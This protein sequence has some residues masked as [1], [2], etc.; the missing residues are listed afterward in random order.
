MKIPLKKFD[1]SALLPKYAALDNI[2]WTKLTPEQTKLLADANND[3]SVKAF[4]S[5]WTQGAR[6]ATPANLFASLTK[7]K[8]VLLKHAPDLALRYASLSVTEQGKVVQALD[9]L[10]KTREF[11]DLILGINGVDAAPALYQIDTW[12]KHLIA[13]LLKAMADNQ[14][15]YQMPNTA[16]YKELWT[17]DDFVEAVVEH[18]ETQELANLLQKSAKSI[19]V[20]M[21]QIMLR[22]HSKSNAI[23]SQW[24][25]FVRVLPEFAKNTGITK[26]IFGQI[27]AGLNA[28]SEEEQE[29]AQELYDQFGYGTAEQDEDE[30]D[31]Q[32]NQEVPDVDS[33][34]GSYFNYYAQHKSDIYKVL[35]TKGYIKRKD[36]YFGFIQKTS[37]S[38]R[39]EKDDDNNWSRVSLTSSLAK[40]QDTSVV[41]L[42]SMPVVGSITVKA[43]FA[44][45]KEKSPYVTE[46]S[47]QKKVTR[48]AL[49]LPLP[50]TK[51]EE[52]DFGRVGGNLQRLHLLVQTK[53]TDFL[54]VWQDSIKA[55]MSEQDLFDVLWVLGSLIHKGNKTRNLQDVIDYFAEI[56]AAAFR[57][58]MMSF[59]SDDESSK[60]VTPI[61]PPPRQ[62]QE[63]QTRSKPQNQDIEE[64]TETQDEDGNTQTYV[65]YDNSAAEQW[66]VDYVT[67]NIEV[68][69]DFMVEVK[70]E[71]DAF[72]SAIKAAIDD[73]PSAIQMVQDG[74]N[75]TDNEAARQWY[76][77]QF[78]SILSVDND[79][80]PYAY[81]LMPT[82]SEAVGRIHDAVV[83]LY[84]STGMLSCIGR[85]SF[86]KSLM[87]NEDGLF[88]PSLTM[89]NTLFPPLEDAPSY[90]TDLFGEVVQLSKDWTV[91]YIDNSGKEVELP[92][93]VV[94][95][96]SAQAIYTWFYSQDL[97]HEEIMAHILQIVSGASFPEYQNA[98]AVAEQ[99]YPSQTA[100]EDDL[101]SGFNQNEAE[102]DTSAFES[103]LSALQ[104]PTLSITVKRLKQWVIN[105]TLCLT[106]DIRSDAILIATIVKSK[107]TRLPQLIQVLNDLIDN[108]NQFSTEQIANFLELFSY[109]SDQVNEPVSEPQAQEAEKPVETQCE[110]PLQQSAEVMEPVLT[111]GDQKLSQP[112][113]TVTLTVTTPKTQPHGVTEQSDTQ[114]VGQ[115]SAQQP[116]QQ[117][118]DES[119]NLF[120]KEDGPIN[121]FP[122]E[123][124]TD[125]LERT[126]AEND[127]LI[128]ALDFGTAF[129]KAVV[130]DQQKGD[131]GYIDLALGKQTQSFGQTQTDSLFPVASAIFIDD[132]GRIWFGPDVEESRQHLTDAMREE[133][134]SCFKLKVRFNEEHDFPDPFKV[135]VDDHNPTAYPITEWHLIV[136]YLSYLVDLSVS[137]LKEQH[138][139]DTRYLA[140]NYVHPCWNFQ[141][142]KKWKPFYNLLLTQAQVLADTLHGRWAEGFTVDQVFPLLEKIKEEVK[143]P[144]QWLI[145][146]DFDEPVA[147]S[148][149]ILTFLDQQPSTAQLEKDRRHLLLVVDAGAGT[150]DFGLFIIKESPFEDDY[151]SGYYD[152]R[153]SITT[154]PNSLVAL[155]QAGNRLDDLFKE[156]LWEQIGTKSSANAS[157]RAEMERLKRDLKEKFC[158]QG[159]LHNESVLGKRIS[160]DTSMLQQFE[161]IKKFENDF[162]M[163]MKKS[164]QSLLELDQHSS[165]WRSGNSFIN[166]GIGLDCAIVHVILT[167]GSSRFPTI[168]EFFN[169][170]I[171]AGTLGIESLFRGRKRDIEFILCEK[172][173]DKFN[174]KSLIENYQQL[175]TVFGAGHV[176]MHLGRINL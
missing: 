82:P 59:V 56:N 118:C 120:A 168:K 165:E 67:R 79:N 75:N 167:G 12:S 104:S 129:S 151:S 14:A 8:A 31:E 133:G 143:T 22:L 142:Q 29:L 110:Q 127:Q 63:G 49:V 81:L 27:Q 18:L 50:Y 35:H 78:K 72:M 23:V 162:F 47:S 99:Y 33:Q 140:I 7:N 130:W 5:A 155:P 154:V 55:A 87:A 90:S 61:T 24:T 19:F 171:H 138:N 91:T 158:L 32:A 48:I 137:A 53:D 136:L 160:L 41:T 70:P 6:G 80:N 175:A 38:E 113:Q 107:A 112:T 125:F 157:E 76:V 102:Y 174:D 64:V 150:T 65:V 96:Q 17:Q 21:Y 149:D 42:A 131:N 66:A 159:K 123:L 97:T 153:R 115:V 132:E 95:A 73:V 16:A 11:D 34:D 44:A 26:E 116:A 20:A 86:Y 176:D 71:F 134:R 98:I 122:S 169:K 2:H 39:L 117:D 36:E 109:F 25:E 30:Q 121:S 101:A 126:S 144:P 106:N 45:L 62:K 88:D 43:L 156:F 83:A 152:L 164:F 170:K 141:Q 94:L 3:A 77:S 10:D 100:N 28:N 46:V 60:P 114:D 1:N 163:A 147:A 69:D 108:T 52:T 172:S 54:L 13:Y 148:A 68:D 51:D 9:L 93:G 84:E 166:S 57:P 85:K 37:L 146:K 124:N 4:P 40:D 139:L 119:L 103:A 58:S 135:K 74:Y 89:W 145:K 92:N 15:L 128:L 111:R 173:S 161:P 105:N